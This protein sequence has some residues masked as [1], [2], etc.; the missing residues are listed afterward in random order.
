MTLLFQEEA[1]WKTPISEMERRENV[2]LK[3]EL[4]LPS[5]VFRMI[6]HRIVHL[7][8]EVTTEK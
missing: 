8:V 7:N 1:V 2:P 6:S 4:S 5:K 3:P